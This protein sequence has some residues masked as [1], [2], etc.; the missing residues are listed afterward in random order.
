MTYPPGHGPFRRI[1]DEKTLR[2]RISSIGRTVSL[3]A[4]PW[5]GVGTWYLVIDCSPVAAWVETRG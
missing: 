4:T 5:W 2:K 1:E 3:T